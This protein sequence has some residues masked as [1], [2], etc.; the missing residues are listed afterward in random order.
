MEIGICLAASISVMIFHELGK[1][2]AYLFC[3]PDNW[4]RLKNVWKLWQYIDPVGL[5]LGV[6]CYVPISKPYFFRIQDKRSNRILGIVGFI[7]LALLFGGSISLLKM[8]DTGRLPVPSS[9]TLLQIL[10][11]YLQY[12]ALLSF[13]MAVAN[14]FPISVFDMGLIIAGISSEKYMGLIRSDAVVKMILVLTLILDVI[15]YAG[16]R[17]LEILL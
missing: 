10:V 16:I 3:K 14:L 5:L 7:M 17:L 6:T 2:A 8:M 15:H 11:L 13:G 9:S 1:A 12:V 4:K